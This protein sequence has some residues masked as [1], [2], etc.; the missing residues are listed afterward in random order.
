MLK[1]AHEVSC[2]NGVVDAEEMDKRDKTSLKNDTYDY[3]QRRYATQ[4]REQFRR[5]RKGRLH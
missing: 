3:T 1:E 5:S 4:S 2:G